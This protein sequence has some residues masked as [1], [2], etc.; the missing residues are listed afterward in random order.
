MVRNSPVLQ[1][2]YFVV[3]FTIASTQMGNSDPVEQTRR[4]KIVISSQRNVLKDSQDLGGIR[5]ICQGP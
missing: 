4:S 1:C 5:C 2:A 3:R